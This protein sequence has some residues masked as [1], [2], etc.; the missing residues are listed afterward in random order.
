MEDLAFRPFVV[1]VPA[2]LLIGYTIFD[3]V[4]RPDLTSLRKA[5]WTVGVVVVPVVGTFIYLLARPFHDPARTT[6]R[7]NERTNAIVALIEQHAVGSISDDDFSAS[8]RRVF[9]DAIAYLEKARIEAPR[10]IARLYLI[11]AYRDK[12]LYESARQELEYLINNTQ[13]D[14]I[15]DEAVSV[16]ITL[17]LITI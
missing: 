8:K 10:D 17:L 4:R 9:D 14:V 11:F 6:R 5:L 12:G 3:I 2:Y 7:G 13:D 1:A 15:R 16:M